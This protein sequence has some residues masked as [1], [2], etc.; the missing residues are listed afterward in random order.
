[1]CGRPATPGRPARSGERPVNR[2]DAIVVGG[3]HNGLACA[4]YLARAGRTVVV[5]EER[6]IVGGFCT[7][8]AVVPEAPGFLMNVTSI[9]HILTCIPTSVADDLDL[10]RHGLEWVWPDPF[11]SYAA[12]EGGVIRFWRDMDRTCAEIARFSKRDADAYRR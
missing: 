11:C 4:A 3:G 2:Y 10:A 9:D 6:P 7:S 5:L 1:P 8:E 12:P